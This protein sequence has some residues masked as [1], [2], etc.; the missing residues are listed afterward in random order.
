MRWNCPHCGTDLAVSD[1][2]LDGGW[3][4][5]RCYKCAGFGLVR[6]PEVS[7]IKIDQIPNGEKVL[8]P[9]GTEMPRLSQ[10]AT[11]NLQ[12]PEAKAASQAMNA[13]AIQQAQQKATL[14]ANANPART[15]AAVTP[16]PFR[17][18]SSFPE[19][20]AEIATSG[21]TRG[22]LRQLASRI[23]GRMAAA[24][25][26]S[27]V[28]AIASG[29]ILLVQGRSILVNSR[30]VAESR[31]SAAVVAD[32]AGSQDAIRTST[33]ANAAVDSVHHNAMAP[34]RGQAAAKIAGSMGKEAH[35]A[36]M[37]VRLNS[38]ETA[39]LRSGPGDDYP[40]IGVARPDLAYEVKS[41]KERWFR[42]LP[43]DALD[44]A[45]EDTVGW[46]RNDLVQSADED[47]TVS[48]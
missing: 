35:P 14:A 17:K 40:V 26:A 8:L 28:V 34:L 37:L 12:R 48:Q 1:D 31:Q 27:A 24:I 29:A 46:I 36:R 6:R 43:A 16:P 4:F 9:E 23:S 7:L 47:R 20:L 33:V 30:T 45:S 39:T 38:A 15:Q 11:Q 22:R 2:R 3:T 21:E 19:P 5:T 13:A 42:I 41:W 18:N 44:S 10:A 25:T 32:Q